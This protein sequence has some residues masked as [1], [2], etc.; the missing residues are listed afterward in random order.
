[1]PGNTPDS[2]GPP[3]GLPEQAADRARAAVEDVFGGAVANIQKLEETPD[4]TRVEADIDG[5]FRGVLIDDPDSDTAAIATASGE[6]Y[7]MHIQIREL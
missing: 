2:A 6:N 7:L 5:V 3:G 4:G 1:M